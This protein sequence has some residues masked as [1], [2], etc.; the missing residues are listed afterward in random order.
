MFMLYVLLCK[1]KEIENILNIFKYF[2]YLL[3]S[4]E[5]GREGEKHQCV[6][7]SCTSPARHLAHNPGMCPD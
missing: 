5:R 7:A 4:R 2:I 6:I 1:Y 3:I